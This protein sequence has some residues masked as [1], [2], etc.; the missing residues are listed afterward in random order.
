MA[1]FHLDVGRQSVG[2]QDCLGSHDEST[3]SL[4]ARN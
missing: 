3:T 2:P 1:W 4:G